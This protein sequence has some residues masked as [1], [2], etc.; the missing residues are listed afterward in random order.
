MPYREKIPTTNFFILGTEVVRV[1]ATSKDIGANAEV[2]YS[3]IGGN[4][5]KKFAIH[6]KTG[7]IT[8]ADMLDYERGKDYFLT[9]Q[10]IGKFYQY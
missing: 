6:N 4:E 10:A 8:I 1:L 5:H 9:I 2:Y 3:I 7:V